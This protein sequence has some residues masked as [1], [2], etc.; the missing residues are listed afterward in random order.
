MTTI[1][2][3]LANRLSNDAGSHTA[4]EHLGNHDRPGVFNFIHAQAPNNFKRT[5]LHEAWTL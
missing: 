1:Y 5:R 3:L 2:P 4:P